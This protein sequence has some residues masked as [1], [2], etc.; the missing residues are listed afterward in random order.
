LTKL[1]IYAMVSVR[2][3]ILTR[4]FRPILFE[5]FY[6]SLLI[7]FGALIMTLSLGGSHYANN[8]S[9]FDLPPNQKFMYSEHYSGVDKLDSQSVVDTT[10]NNEIFKPVHFDLEGKDFP[11]R[12]QNFMIHVYE[13]RKQG[14]TYGSAYFEKIN[15]NESAHEYN[16]V[17]VVDITSQ[18]VLA[19]FTEFMSTALLRHST[20]DSELSLNLSYGSFPRSKMVDHV[21][22]TTI[23]IMTVISFSLAVG[24]ITSAIAANLVMERNDTVKHQ[25]IISGASIFAYWASVYIIDIFKFITPALSFT[26]VTYVMDF[27]VEYAWLLLVLVILSVLPFTY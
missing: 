26:I 5:I 19:Y 27:E 22:T 25:Q 14:E 12:Y 20:G 23:A 16:V 9:I 8:I 6:P 13:N 21:L 10:F 18:S 24:S 15:L 7:V 3:K 2:F 17:S 1:Q 4:N 11:S